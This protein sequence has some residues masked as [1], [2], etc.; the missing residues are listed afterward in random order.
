MLLSSVL[1]KTQKSMREQ[2]EEML[3]KQQENL[4]AKRQSSVAKHAPQKMS[5]SEKQAE[6]EKNESSV[7][8]NLFSKKAVTMSE[9]VTAMLKRHQSQKQ[10]EANKLAGLAGILASTIDNYD[11]GKHIEERREWMKDF[12]AESGVKSVTQMKSEAKKQLISDQDRMTEKERKQAIARGE[13]LPAETPV[14]AAPVRT[15]K[16]QA[17]KVTSTPV[18]KPAAPAIV[19]KGTYVRIRV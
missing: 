5:V 15:A 19:P 8:S 4:V 7:V 1:E 12:S 18:A 3:K 13:T 6:I 14:A 11:L 16:V 2:I 9:G 17:P 10:L